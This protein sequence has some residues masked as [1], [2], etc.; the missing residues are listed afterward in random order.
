L[1]SN[2]GDNHQ[3]TGEKQFMPNVKPIP[4]GYHS[5]QPYLIL[6]DCADAIAFYVKAFGAKEKFRMPD[7]QGRITHAEIEIGDSCVMVADE[8]PQIDALSPEHYGGSPASLLIY[9]GDCDAMYKQALA[10]G[11]KSVR[12]P[13]DQP[14]GDRMSG[15]KDPFGYKWWIAM[16]IKDVSIQDI[17]KQQ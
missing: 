12:E 8:A 16:H 1:S 11:A 15:V 10:T 5:V 14:Y 2:P 4:D 3:R 17:Q 9:T 7:K 6:Q 13:A